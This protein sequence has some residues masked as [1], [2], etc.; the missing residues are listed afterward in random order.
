LRTGVENQGSRKSF[1]VW[2]K[3]V[4]LCATGSWALVKIFLF[5]SQL[6]EKRLRAGA[7]GWQIKV[8]V[9]IKSEAPET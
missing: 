2:K 5:F 9:R 3:N 1:R 6:G 7:R 4:R 8:G